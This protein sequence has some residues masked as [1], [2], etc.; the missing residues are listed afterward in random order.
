M[1]TTDRDLLIGADQIALA[2]FGS[3]GSS[4]RRKIYSNSLKLPLFRS[5]AAVCARKSAIAAMLDKR[6]AAAIAA[7]GEQA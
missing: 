7:L 3:D 1:Q 4:E 5:G 6:E 2:V